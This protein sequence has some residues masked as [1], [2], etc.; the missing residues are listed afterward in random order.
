M[1]D[2]ADIS[3]E[4]LARPLAI[5]QYVTLCCAQVLTARQHVE[6]RS[7]AG[8]CIRVHYAGNNGKE[9]ALHLPNEEIGIAPDAPIKASNMPGRTNPFTLFKRRAFGTRYIRFSHTSVAPARNVIYRYYKPI[10][11]N[12]KSIAMNYVPRCCKSLTLSALFF[13]RSRRFSTF[14][15]PVGSTKLANE[16]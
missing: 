10:L 6:Q 16:M 2:V 15:V 14:A 8:S 7:L 5:D 13:A 1:F 11:Q 9:K 12:N 4:R 3:V